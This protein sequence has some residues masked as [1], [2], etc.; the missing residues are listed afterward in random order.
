MFNAYQTGIHPALIGNCDA[1]QYY[2]P[3]GN[4]GENLLVYIPDG[5]DDSAVTHLSS[6]SGDLG[7]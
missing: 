5:N 1:R 2:L 3:Y 4:E 7:V 6:E